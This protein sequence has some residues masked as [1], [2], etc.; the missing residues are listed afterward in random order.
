MRHGQTGKDTVSTSLHVVDSTPINDHKS[1]L[2]NIGTKDSLTIYLAEKA[3]KINIPLVTVTQLHVHCNQTIFEPTT[4]V[5]SQEEADTVILLHAAE[6]GAAG[7][8]VHI[9]TQDTDELVLA[10]RRL[11]FI[12]PK[13]S[14]IMGTG[15]YRRLMLLKSIYDQLGASKAV[16]LAGFHCLT[17]CDTCGHIRGKSKTSA[18]SVFITSPHEVITALT[19]LGTGDIPSASVVSGCE[20]FLCRLLSTK[21]KIFTSSAELRWKRFKNKPANQGIEK[22]PPTSGAWY[23]GSYASVYLEPR[24]CTTS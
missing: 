21:K 7:K 11:S 8:T 14:L 20:E 12:G 19:H 3:L 16:A 17:G 9:M 10:L 23:Q 18:F 24:S 13:V 6:L 2:S 22:I 5:S 4:T 15:E 1:F